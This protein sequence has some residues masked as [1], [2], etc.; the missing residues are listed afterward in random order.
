MRL[1]RRT[2]RPC[3]VSHRFCTIFW[4]AMS[5]G[6]APPNWLRSLLAWSFWARSLRPWSS[7]NPN[8]SGGGGMT[9]GTVVVVVL[10]V[11]VDVDVEVEVV[12][13]A[14]A[15]PAATGVIPTRARAATSGTAPRHLPHIPLDVDIFTPHLETR[16]SPTR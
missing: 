7:G 9:S 15:A 10:E 13:P 6:S 3:N 8:G 12:E 1:T 11:D 4:F 16:V 14:P 2:K 5:R